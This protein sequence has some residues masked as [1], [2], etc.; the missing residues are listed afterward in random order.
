MAITVVEDVNRVEVVED[1]NQLTVQVDSP[2]VS[3]LEQPV[4]LTITQQAPTVQVSSAGVQGLRGLQGVPGPE[5]PQGPA[6]PPGG[7]FFVYTQSVPAS[8]WVIDHNLGRKVQV[9]L[10]ST[11][12]TVVYADITHGSVNQTTVTFAAPF[13]GSAVLS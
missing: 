11:L 2:S 8:T 7:G 5:G 9:S 1:G 4:T 13:A 6:G 3:V 10:F 12:N